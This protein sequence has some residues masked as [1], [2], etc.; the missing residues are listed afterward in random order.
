LATSRRKGVLAFAAQPITGDENRA[1]DLDRVVSE[2]SRSPGATLVVQ[3]H[4]QRLPVARMGAAD[5]DAILRFLCRQEVGY[6]AAMV[7]DLCVRC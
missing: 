5:T 3:A 4:S 2:I 1:A 7:L 6:Q